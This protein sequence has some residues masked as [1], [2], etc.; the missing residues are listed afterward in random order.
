MT[1]EKSSEQFEQ[2]L[3]TRLRREAEQVPPEVSARLRAIRS[4]A[5][6]DS[7]AAADWRRWPLAAVAAAAVLMLA[8]MINVRSPEDLPQLPV[9]D[10]QELAVVEDLELLESLEFLAWLEEAGPNAG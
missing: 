1:Q 8:L 10:A 5:I 4:E 7:S 3:A 2:A 9:V 6:A